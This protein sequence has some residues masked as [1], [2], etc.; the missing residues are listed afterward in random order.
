MQFGDGEKPMFKYPA[1]IG[2]LVKALRDK[3]P[4]E[5]QI[6]KTKIQK[7]LFLLT[8]KHIVDF[9]Y[10]M[11]YYGPYSP[12]VS[13]E[14]LVAETAGII[15]SKWKDDKGFFIEKGPNEKK[16][17]EE[18]EKDEISAIDEIVE[19]FGKYNAKKFTILATLLFLNDKK[20]FFSKEDLVEEVHRIKKYPVQDIREVL[21]DSEKAGYLVYQK[22]K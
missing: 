15:Q 5:E 11:H 21:E 18:I 12:E 22:L 10:S 9:D 19:V 3:H 6:G 2:Y 17:E 14:L 4:E 1:M 7:I 8:R 13:N 16:F 20:G